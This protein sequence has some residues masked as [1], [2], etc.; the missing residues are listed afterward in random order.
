MET[1]EQIYRHLRDLRDHL[2]AQTGRAAE[3]IDGEI[4]MVMSP[5]PL[6][7]LTAKRIVRQLDAQLTPPLAAFEST[8]T[9]EEHLGKLRIPDIVVVPEQAMERVDPRAPPR[10]GLVPSPI[11]S[12]RRDRSGCGL[13]H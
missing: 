5:V 13:A 6:H 4:V 7:G 9:D 10:A 11:G 2:M 12:G 1:K 3:I 8:D